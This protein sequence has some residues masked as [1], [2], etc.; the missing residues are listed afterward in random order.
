MCVDNMMI[1]KD[2][3][4]VPVQVPLKH[5]YELS[6][7]TLTEFKSN[8][9]EIDLENGLQGVGEVTALPGYGQ[10]TAADVTATL[11][12]A[13][14]ALPGRSVGEAKQII[15]AM[16]AN[17]PFAAATIGA[18]M[19]DACGNVARPADMKIP[20]LHPVAATS[21]IDR[22]L[23]SVAE[24][25]KRGFKTIKV[26]V[27]REC[28]IDILTARELIAAFGQ[29]SFRFD[30]NQGYSMEEAR[31]FLDAVVP[32]Q[33][34]AFEYLEQPLPQGSWEDDRELN[35][36]YPGHLML[37][38]SIYGEEDIA[39]ASSIGI[40]L[41]KLKL[42]KTRGMQDLLR[43]IR[44]AGTHDISVILGNGVATDVGNMAEATV[45]SAAGELCHG[46]FEGNGFLKICRLLRY[47]EMTEEDGNL[48][49]PCRK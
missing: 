27:G 33:A 30:A 20:L 12:R 42:A 11:A 3:R 40:R 18:A 48:V 47:R 44:I 46:A 45:F 9:F 26:K 28:S 7:A 32:M 25:A 16:F 38:E 6:F 29:L 41:V 43:L 2:A 21:D 15:D 17:S 22:L 13:Q 34:E 37:D 24:A 19:D 5:P 23:L 49:W 8:L 36:Q 31:A 14:A 1:V 35:R 4:S 39:H 10:E